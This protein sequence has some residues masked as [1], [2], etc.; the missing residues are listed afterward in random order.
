MDLKT[1]LPFFMLMTKAGIELLQDPE[2]A[3]PSD[4]AFVAQLET[5]DVFER[6]CGCLVAS[7]HK[8]FDDLLPAIVPHLTDN[9][10]V[11][12]LRSQPCEDAT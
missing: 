11:E 6:S 5:E 2:H 3:A 10:V 4:Q 8:S 1:G 7:Y 12:C 9:Q